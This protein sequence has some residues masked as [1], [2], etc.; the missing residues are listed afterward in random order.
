MISD[1]LIKKFPNRVPVIFIPGETIGMKRTKFLIHS[2]Y[3]IGQVMTKVKQNMDVKREEAIFI[4]ANKT[5]VPNSE[6]LKRVWN[7]H[8]NPHDGILYLN[9]MKENTFG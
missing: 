2:D 9:L 7:E 3:S 1:I 5:L 8:K 6:L 4:L